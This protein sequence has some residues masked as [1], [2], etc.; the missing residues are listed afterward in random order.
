[1]ISIGIIS[2]EVQTVAAAVRRCCLISGGQTCIAASSVKPAPTVGQY[3]GGGG[4]RTSNT[5][6]VLFVGQTCHSHARSRESGGDKRAGIFTI[7]AV[8]GD[9]HGIG[10]VAIQ[11]CKRIRR[12]GIVINNPFLIIVGCLV[13]HATAGSRS[14]CSLSRVGG[15]IAYG[16]VGRSG[17]VDG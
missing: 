7:F 15:D 14:P 16:Q 6:E 17:A 12:G 4:G 5:V 8:V 9:T 1:M 11:A 3:I 2:V 10:G 13:K